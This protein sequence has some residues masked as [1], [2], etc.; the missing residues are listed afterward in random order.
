AYRALIE[1]RREHGLGARATKSLL[2][3]RLARDAEH[4]M[5]GGEARLGAAAALGKQERHGLPSHERL[6]RGVARSFRLDEHAA[7]AR[8][9]TRPGRRLHPRREC[10]LPGVDARAREGAVW[11]E[12]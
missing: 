12:D 3:R 2:E 11:I 7:A 9:R 5:R 6:D 1:A 10:L 8:L 4:R